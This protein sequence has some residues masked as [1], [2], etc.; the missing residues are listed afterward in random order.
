MRS[1]KDTQG[2]DW[3]VAV[4]TA[5]V[6]RVRDLAGV[7]LLKIVESGPDGRNLLSDLLDDPVRLVDVL[8]VVCKPDADA[9]GVTDEQF[10]GAMS[11][12]A[13]D[14]GFTALTE[15]LADF[16]P[17]P[18]HRQALRSLL[19]KVR[20][21]GELLMRDA[22]EAVEAINPAEHAEEQRK[23]LKRS[24]GNSPES[25]ASILLR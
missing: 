22:A 19:T 18:R 24:S 14:A 2:R 8:Y 4:N 6:K 21:T 17:Q 16:F 10:G 3:P 13:I 9:R 12:D 23:K 20:E 7:N 1:F 11:G 15:D 5:T 25:P